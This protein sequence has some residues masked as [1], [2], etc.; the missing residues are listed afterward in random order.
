M[1]EQGRLKFNI[2][3]KL[4]PL[5]KELSTYTGVGKSPDRMDAAVFSWMGVAPM[6][7]NTLKIMEFNL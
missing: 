5:F 7:A 6:K 3:A 1:F 2:D 4:D